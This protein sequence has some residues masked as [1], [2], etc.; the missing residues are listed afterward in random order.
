MAVSIKNCKSAPGRNRIKRVVRESFRAHQH[1]L[2]GKGGLDLV[3]LPSRQAATICNSELT[4]SLERHW[5]RICGTEGPAPD[6]FRR[7]Q[8]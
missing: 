7:K 6:N 3:V 1:G 5:H 2:A 8:E 4:A